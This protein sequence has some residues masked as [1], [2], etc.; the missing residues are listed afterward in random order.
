MFGIV[1]TTLAL[2]VMVYHLFAGILPLG[3]Y[4]VFGFYIVS[5]YLMTLIMS[6]TYG[7]TKF[8]RYSFAVNRFL[9]LYPQY[10]AA[11]LLSLLLIFILG[12]EAA[13]NYHKSMFIPSSLQGVMQ[14]LFMVFPSWYPN[15]V[16]PRLVPPIW[17]VTVELFFYAL[18]CLGISKTFNRV[19]IWML[20]SCCYVVGSYAA[21]WSWQDRYFPVAAASL[22]FSIG[23]A[24]Y[25]ISKSSTLPKFCHNLGLLS[26]FSFFLMLANCLI[27]M[28]LSKSNIGKLVE[29]GLYI[30]LF[31]CSVLVFSLAQGSHII[32]VNKKTDKVIGDFSY[33]IYLLHQQSGFLISSLMLGAPRH[34]ISSRGLIGLAGAI[35]LVIILS[36]IFIAF[37][38]KPIDRIRSKIKS[39]KA[40][41]RAFVSN[42]GRLNES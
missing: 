2:M 18:I 11:S 1:R 26:S 12:L 14:N 6:E 8:G 27:W 20:L 38:N 35:L 37:I 7:Y 4:P 19:K 41:L 10:W 9:R 23:S 22:P 30:N 31:I 17:A 34:E 28:I 42:A 36:L 13:N 33:P 15:K 16:N 24:I 21:G 32:K 3:T 39:N 5:G 40:L 25:F 29:V